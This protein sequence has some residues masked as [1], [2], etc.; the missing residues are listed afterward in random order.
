ML[1]LVHPPDGGKESIHPKGKRRMA[2]A[3][4]D[5]E[6]MRFRA[7]L[8]NLRALYGSWP[9]LADVMGVHP[10]T[11]RTIAYGRKRPSAAI[12]I[13]AARAAGET[14]DRMIAPPFNAAACP[15][16]GARRSA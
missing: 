3:F 10:D 6:A 5:T 2:P 14:L 8:R 12:G 16:C 7:A 1:R 15:H 9:C 4:T 13:A 11:L